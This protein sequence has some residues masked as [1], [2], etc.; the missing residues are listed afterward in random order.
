[1]RKELVAILADVDGQV[2][3]HVR[4]QAY[5]QAFALSSPADDR[6]LIE[7]VLHDPDVGMAESAV[8]EHVER[9]AASREGFAEWAASIADLVAG[10]DFLTTRIA[11]WL[12]VLGVVDGRTD[13]VEAVIEASDWCQRTVVATV[14]SDAV[15][16]RLA[17]AGRTKR[18]RNAARQRLSRE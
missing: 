10:H 7:V 12:V 9:R 13:L 14:E 11:E 2:D 18:V 8:G 6:A 1:M 5:R 17:E 15:L 4:Y 16:R 3:E